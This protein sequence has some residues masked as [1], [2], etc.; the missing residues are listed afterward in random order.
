MSKQALQGKKVKCTKIYVLVYRT[1]N[2]L[3]R[4]DGVLQNNS[5]L[6]KML[7]TENINLNILGNISPYFIPIFIIKASNQIRKNQNLKLIN[8]VLTYFY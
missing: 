3:V 7:C 6:Q 1:N 2:V 5:M 8:P 4:G